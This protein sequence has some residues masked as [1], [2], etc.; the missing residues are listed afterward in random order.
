MT[1]TAP[2]T[3]DE[4]AELNALR[5]ERDN[6]NNAP[7]TPD[8]EPL[9]DTHWLHLGDGQVIRSK[10]VT[11]HVDGIPVIHAV[12]IPSDLTNVPEAHRF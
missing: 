2:L 5:S 6:V 1:D 8:Q 4:R 10:G 9:P 11:T 12:E 7:A 3:D